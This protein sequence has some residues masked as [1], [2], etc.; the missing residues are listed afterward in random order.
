MSRAPGPAIIDVAGTA[1]AEDDR[2]RLRHPAVGGVILF[3]RNYESPPQLLALVAEIRTLRPDI[4]LCV[5]HE[6]GRSHVAALVRHTPDQSRRQ[7][8]RRAETTRL[9]HRPAHHLSDQLRF[10]MLPAS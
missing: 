3:A 10:L 7:A 1:L 6:G 2:A 8:Q 4:L 9:R 5:D